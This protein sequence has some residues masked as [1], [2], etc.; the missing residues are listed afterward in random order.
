MKDKIIFWSF[1]AGSS[2]GKVEPG[3][4]EEAAA[5]RGRVQAVR[6]VSC[7]SPQPLA[8]FMSNE[9]RISCFFF[10]IARRIFRA[11]TECEPEKIS[12]T[13]GSSTDLQ[14]K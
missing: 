13:G 10:F 2:G 3:F 7:V 11:H 14:E 5:H 4:A 6:V 9:Q 12:S 1:D 8:E